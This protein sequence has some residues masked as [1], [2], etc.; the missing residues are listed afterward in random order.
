[1][2]HLDDVEKSFGG[3]LARAQGRVVPALAGV[4]LTVPAGTV[5]GIVGPNG[6]GKSTLIRILLGYLRPTRGN[7]TMGGLAPRAYAQ[8][9]GIAYVPESPAIRP[10]WT[11]DY[12]MR[13]YASLAEL[14]EPGPQIDAALER[15]GLG[16]LRLRRVGTLS[17]GVRQRLALAQSLLG[18]RSVMVLDEPTSGLDPEWVTELRGM[19][20]EWRA[21]RADRVALIA[22]HD[23]SELERMVDR[24]AVLVGGVVRE[25]IDLRA[26][27]QAY[28]AYRLSWNP[29]PT[30]TTPCGPAF[31][32]RCP[33]RGRRCGSGWS[34]GTAKT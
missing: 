13:F 27:T 33:R 14:G 31:P 4:S 23:L 24:A 7:V 34:P 18:D 9:H 20:A 8:R 25:V 15:V 11:V 28:P 16:D 2:I 32:A 1:M 19:V 17:K 22:S 6:A 12:A 29:P 5:L 10:G 30:P 3:W 21:G 26:G